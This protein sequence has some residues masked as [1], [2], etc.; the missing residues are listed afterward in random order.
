M[1]KEEFRAWPLVDAN[2][3]MIPGQCASPTTQPHFMCM[4]RTSPRESM[5]LVLP[6]QRTLS[7]E[8]LSDLHSPPSTLRYS[9]GTNSLDFSYTMVAQEGL[10]LTSKT[11]Q[12]Q[13][14]YDRKALRPASKIRMKRKRSTPHGATCLSMKRSQ[15]LDDAITFATTSGQFPSLHKVFSYSYSCWK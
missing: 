6:L 4:P 15:I 2:A 10:S 8:A 11:F 7:N 5:P 14:T 1:R 3:S 9:R 13:L 12:W